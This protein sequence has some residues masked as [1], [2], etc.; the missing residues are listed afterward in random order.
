MVKKEYTFRGKKIEEL[1]EMALE[2]FAKLLP[3]R[4]RR[5]LTRGFNDSQKRLLDR[6]KRF[7]EGKT[8]KPI[9]TH[10]R[11]MI[12]I[13]SMVNLTIHIHNGK[14]FGQILIQPEM[15]GHYLGEFAL[16]RQRIA[17]SAPGIGAT[18]SSAAA[19]VK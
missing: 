16:T 15:V 19:S 12:V 1:K 4:Q 3:S 5:S 7:K 13:P 11:N 2:D 10:C 6:I 8:K 14:Q 9:K 18:K 17:H